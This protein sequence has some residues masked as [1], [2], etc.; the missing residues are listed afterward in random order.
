MDPDD[1]GAFQHR[2]GSALLMGGVPSL[3]QGRDGDR[4][5]SPEAPT[6]LG[7]DRRRRATPLP[8]P[9]PTHP[10]HEGRRVCG[11]GGAHPHS[12]PPPPPT[13]P[14][15]GASFCSGLPRCC[16]ERCRCAS[17]SASSRVC[18]CGSLQQASVCPTCA[19]LIPGIQ[20]GVCVSGCE[21]CVK[22]R[23]Q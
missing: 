9:A 20:Q 19:S 11:W 5:L 6:Q 21:R 15:P 1:G 8:L 22:P 4:E 17:P 3:H 12:P 14:T 18:A 2:R 16:P 7:G 10:T 23:Q 13:T